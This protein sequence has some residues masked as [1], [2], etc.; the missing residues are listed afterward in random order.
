M[1]HGVFGTG[2]AGPVGVGLV[3]LLVAFALVAVWVATHQQRLAR[4]GHLGGLPVIGT[5]LHWAAERWKALSRPLQ[6]RMGV[7]GVALAGLLGGLVV[8]GLTGIGF[9]VL[10]DDV[11]EGEG[12]ARF[13]QPAAAWLVAHREV[14]LTRALLTVTRMGNTDAQTVWVLLVCVLA[15]VIARS[16]APVAVGVTAGGGI[17]LVI[18]VAKHLVGRQRPALP[19]AVIPVDGF[20]FP[21][22]HAT[23]A[24]AV[25]VV[26][27]WM[28]C[29]WVVHRWAA[30]VAVWAVTLTAVA[31]IGFSRTY[32]GVHFVTDVLAGWMLGAA[33]AASVIVI[34]S[35]WSRGIRTQ[36]AITQRSGVPGLD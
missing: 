26:C 15:A 19:F 29:R 25:G 28:L 9:T 12:I 17:G 35:W 22:G 8:V 24:A 7:G 23:G 30:Q 10:L 6:T 21:S 13:D 14:W 3:V 5:P 16:W 18:V 32:L 11:L 2:S 31:L 4:L 33:W 34:A 1:E 20:S 36:G 27:A